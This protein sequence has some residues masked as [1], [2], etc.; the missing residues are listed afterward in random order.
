MIPQN[1]I[2]SLEVWLN[3]EITGKRR[4]VAALE[5]QERSLVDSKS[6]DITRATAVVARELE[7][8]IE[9][10]RRREAIFARL[11]SIWNVAAGTLTLGSIADRAGASGARLDEL[12]EVLRTQ[13]AEVL[14]RNRRIARLVHVHKSIVEETITALIGT[15]A[16]EGATGALFDARM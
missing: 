1:F 5:A 4:L 14:R 11:G 10:S 2:N 9:R 16:P 15:H 13:V 12:R 3:D 8:E 7:I 6:E